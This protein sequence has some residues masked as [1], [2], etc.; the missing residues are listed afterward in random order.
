MNLERLIAEAAKRKVPRGMLE[1][2]LRYAYIPQPK[3]L[4]F[5]AAAAE[6]QEK[7]SEV[8]YI[9]QGGSR[10]SSKTHTT[11]AQVGLHDCQTR[12]GLKFLFLRRIGLSARESFEDVTSKVFKG[13]DYRPPTGND[14]TLRFN[15]NGSTIRFGGYKDSSDI[16]K[17]IGIEYDGICIEEATQLEEEK[18]E[19]IDGSLRTSRDDWNSVMYLTFNPEGVGLQW[20][21][22]RFVEPWKWG[23]QTRTRFILSSY[24]DN[25]YTDPRYVTF[26]ENIQDGQ[27]AKAWRDGDFDVFYGHGFPNFNKKTHVIK[28]FETPRY[29]SYWIGIDDGYADPFCALWLTRST[30]PPYRTYVIQ[31]V[32]EKGRVNSEQA[33]IIKDTTPKEW[34]IKWYVADP[35]MFR[36]SRVDSLHRTAA[37]IYRQNGIRLIKGNNKRIAG[38]RLVDDYFAL[39]EDGMPKLQIFDTCPNLIDEIM[40]LTFDP[41]RPEDV[42]QNMPDHAYASLRYALG[43]VEQPKQ[44]EEEIDEMTKVALE[45]IGKF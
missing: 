5:H 14:K 42:V 2:F 30:Q 32:Y 39:A 22:R 18:L 20:A 43:R 13:M 29:W 33:M 26:L 12:P 24:K 41:K 1:N 27:L 10:S 34:R 7:D 38:K 35:E 28:P 16:D 25:A 21:K 44:E 40:N 19:R 9:G 3:Q 17:Y 37:D 23:E 4:D 6:A 15:N 31:E 45:A 36:V 8:R 11:L